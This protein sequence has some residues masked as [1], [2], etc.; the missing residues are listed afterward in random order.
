M[1]Q[2]LIDKKL[3]HTQVQ[4]CYREMVDIIVRCTSK[5]AEDIFQDY[6]RKHY[7][8]EL[9]EWE[10]IAPGKMWKKVSYTLYRATLG[11]QR[12]KTLLRFIQDKAAPITDIWNMLNAIIYNLTIIYKLT[13]N[14]T[15][16]ELLLIEAERSLW[17]TCQQNLLNMVYEYRE[18][19][20]K[21]KVFHSKRIVYTG[22]ICNT[23]DV[24]DKYLSENLRLLT[25]DLDEL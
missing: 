17:S 11:R 22:K 20:M 19:V 4:R 15:I 25:K 23:R 24:K 21:R 1:L 7:E 3:D 18:Y 9:R 5:K 14:F 12:F 13:K 2:V 10:K 6:N 8:R 16:E